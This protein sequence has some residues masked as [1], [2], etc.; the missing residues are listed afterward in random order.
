MKEVNEVFIQIF[1]VATYTVLPSLFT[2][3]LLSLVLMGHYVSQ[4]FHDSMSDM[5][6]LPGVDQRVE[7]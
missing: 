6:H 7:R 1:K 3:F 4:Y 5:S 2:F